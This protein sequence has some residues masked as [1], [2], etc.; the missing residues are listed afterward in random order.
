MVESLRELTKV[1]ADHGVVLAMQN[2]GPDVV[3]SYRDVLSLITEVGSPVL[4][5]CM[6]INI[7]PEAESAETAKEM[8]RA[9]GDLT[10][11][12][13]V[14]GEFYRQSDG[15]VALTGSGY[16]D[17]RFWQRRTAYPAYFEALAASGYGGYVDW[18]F[19]HPA[20]RDGKPAGI[21][22]IHEQTRLALEYM[23]DLRSAAQAGCRT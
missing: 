4:K 7:E 3:N 11:H 23:K 6:D 19:C 15:R 18:E 20:I 2:H 13:H 21:D 16:Y 5:A 12:S 22:Y 9:S 14:N 10:V 17:Q 8:V 1:A